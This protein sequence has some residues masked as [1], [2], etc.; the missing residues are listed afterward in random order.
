MQF[1]QKLAFSLVVALVLFSLP[2]AFGQSTTA[3]DIAGIVT[4]PTG[5]VVPGANVTLKGLSTGTTA[6]A[7][8]NAQG[9]YR[10]ALLAPGQ[11]T[12]TVTAAGFGKAEKATPAA[13]GQLTSVDFQLAVAEQTQTVEITENA[14]TVQTENGDIATTIVSEQLA[15]LPNP[16]NDLSFVAQLAPGAVMNTQ[17]GYGNFEVFGLPGTSNVFTYNGQYDNDPFLNLNNSGATNLLLGNNDVAEVNVVV[18]GYSGQYGGLAGAQVNYVSKSGSN[19]FHGNAAWFWN[20]RIMNANDWFNNAYGDSRPFDNVNQWAASFGGPIRKDK[21]F[22]FWNYE[23]LR[24]L[25]PTSSTATIPSPQFESATLTN[26]TA[27]GLSAS[28]PF[29]QSMFNLYNAAPGAA[30]A[31]ATPGGGCSDVTALPAGVPCTEQFRSVA[32]NFTH[33]YQTSI[34]IDQNIGQ[35]DRIYGRVQ[36]D[37]GIQA[38]YTDPISPV[39]NAVSNQPE[40]QG[41]LNYTHSFGA[42]ATNQFVFSGQYYSAI[43]STPNLAS[44]LSAFPTTMV[45]LDGSLTNLGGADVDWPEGRNVRQWQIVDDFTI[46]SGRHTFK[47]GINWRKNDVQDFDYGSYTSGLELE[48]SLNN[49]FYGGAAPG[50]FD[51]LEQKF[52]TAPSEPIFLW[53]MGIYG[54]D[55]FRV[56]RNLKITAALRID[57]NAN[58]QCNTNCFSQFAV[59]FTELD[60][61]ASIPYNQA[62][63]TNLHTAYYSTDKVVWQ[64]RV[65][66]AWSPNEKTVVRGGAGIFSDGFPA[67][68]V[69]SFSSNPPNVNAFIVTGAPLSPA[70]SGNL[71]SLASGSNSSFTSAFAN[72]GTLAS[73]EASNPFFS[74]PSFSS[75]DQRIRQPHYYEWNLEV[76]REIGWHTILDVNYVGNHGAYEP[77]VNSGLNAYDPAGFAGLPTA[78]PDPRF[79]TV[80]QYASSDYS[81]YDG[82]IVRVNHSFSKGLLFQLNYSWSHALDVCSNGC[83]EQFGLDT[84]ASILSPQNPLD[85]RANYGNADYDVRHYFSANYVWDDVIRRFSHWGPNAVFGGW[86]ISGTFFVR[87]GFPF[88]VVDTAASGTLSGYNDGGP[89]F[90]NLVGSGV[91]SCGEGAAG[92]TPT[93]CVNASEFS[94]STSN[95]TAFGNQG[96]NTF[97]GPGYFNTDMAI[98]KAF[99]FPRWESAKLTIG[100]QAFNLLNHPNFDQ[101]VNDL[102]NTNPTTGFGDITR[103][104]NPPTSILGSFLGGDASTR[105]IQVKLQFQF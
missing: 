69:D 12:V 96:R 25:L 72:G 31:A 77:L 65:G 100:A 97:R 91:G 20:G 49:F 74:P 34:R 87:S 68:I 19:Q 76:Q 22:F 66:F 47:A 80:T 43:F 93:P 85:A 58:P 83:L 101:P 56:G 81:N 7:T 13:I 73:I 37:Q 50:G 102:A 90:G 99:R 23:G 94:P 55:E 82:L 36:T 104:V 54:Q 62:I 67:L 40:Y 78:P 21:T 10:F 35:N 60:H 52:L 61:D 71:F 59:P 89:Y 84:A 103:T 79:G 2:V 88:T 46:T 51:L 70:Q 63:E 105:M 32:G 39:F 4:D 17:G 38:T 28:I 14:A 98:S 53:N 92:L 64:P 42:R 6:V 9:Y 33:E 11:Y 5:A 26:L 75:E 3:G 48:G 29:Y 57:H 44:S 16:G 86:T 41:Q 95:P 18:N 8:T 30:A 1:H 15:N 27:Q 24:V 45:M